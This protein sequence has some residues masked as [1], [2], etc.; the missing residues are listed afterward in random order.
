MVKKICVISLVG[1]LILAG[2]SWWIHGYYQCQKYK[3]EEDIIAL[4][5]NKKAMFTDVAEIF[6]SSSKFWNEVRRDEY[7]HYARLRS[8]YDTKKIECFIQEDQ[9]IITN[10]FQET[11]PY[12]VAVNKFYVTRNNILTEDR[13]ITINYH[14]N[15]G[16]KT[17]ILILAYYYGDDR[18][19]WIEK[20]K[21]Y[22][23]NLV[24]LDDDWVIH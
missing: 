4:F 16:K 23:P 19:Q 9:E 20:I 3:R 6:A 10:F 2:F 12:E 24:E 21:G 13:Y 17:G 1:I 8:P 15:K 11:R 14:F 18:D 22:Y 7:D 5:E